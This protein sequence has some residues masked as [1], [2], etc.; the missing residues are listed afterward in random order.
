MRISLFVASMLL[1]VAGVGL[2]FG[3]NSGA[4]A[5]TYS[6]AVLCQIFVFLPEFKKFKGLGIEAEL[7]G[8]KIEEA[9]ELLSRL[10]NIAVPLAEMSFSSSVRMG[11]W[12]SGIPRWKRHEL[13]QKIEGELQRCGVSPS[14][15]ELA[16]GDV[17]FF[18]VIDLTFP[19]V[20]KVQRV[21]EAKWG[22]RDVA[23][24]NFPQPVMPER[25]AEFDALVAERNSAL[26]ER[27]R[28]KHVPLMGFGSNVAGEIRSIVENSHL[29]A[30]GE[31]TALF[32]EIDE[33]LK[34]LEH[35]LQFKAFRRP[36][37]WFGPDKSRRI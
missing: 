16:K 12:D 36:D 25:R 24:G 32:A 37:I 21:F 2:A 4:A 26:A 23:V 28:L 29:I 8:R 20:E 13:I 30:G 3:G 15:I 33:E 14:D 5:T 27:E 22:P 6:A 17:H 1:F 9:D 7:L 34:D 18:N 10:R 11:R 31:K 35:Y 19:I